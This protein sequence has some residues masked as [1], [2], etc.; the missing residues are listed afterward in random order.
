MVVTQ[1]MNA[2]LP[3]SYV[4]RV[5]YILIK[6]SWVRSWASSAVA[7]KAIADVVD[8][9]VVALDDLL[10]GRS[11]AANAATDKQ[12]DNLGFFQNRTPR[13]S[14]KRKPRRGDEA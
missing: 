13:T 5:R 2:P 4:L 8:A 14:L 7:G 1:V 9:P 3:E 6:T 11:V 12:S 10:P